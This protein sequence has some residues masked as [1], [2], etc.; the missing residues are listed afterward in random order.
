MDENTKAIYKRGAIFVIPAFVF[1]VLYL[2]VRLWI[3]TRTPKVDLV[4]DQ[5]AMVGDIIAYCDEVGWDADPCAQAVVG[6]R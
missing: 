6:D 1:A 2:G 3:A 4:L 5:D